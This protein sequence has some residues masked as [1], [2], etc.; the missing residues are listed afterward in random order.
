[1]GVTPSRRTADPNLSVVHFRLSSFTLRFGF[2]HAP[3]NNVA[4]T[5]YYACIEGIKEADGQARKNSAEF[6]R[7]RVQVV[8]CLFI[9]VIAFFVSFVFIPLGFAGGD[10]LFGII[11]IILLVLALA[12]LRFFY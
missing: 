8:L 9:M 11:G 7:L 3:T 2:N 1:M 4:P 12:C 5:V 10:I 6:Y